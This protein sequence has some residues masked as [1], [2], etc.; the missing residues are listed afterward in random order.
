[1]KKLLISILVFWGVFFSLVSCSPA[2]LGN[3]SQ[4]TF[5]N[6]TDASVELTCSSFVDASHVVVPA[7][8][9]KTV[10]IQ[11][12]LDSVLVTATG[13]YYLYSSNTVNIKSSSSSCTLKPNLA[14]YSL[15][16]LT[17]AT[18]D[19]PNI[20]KHYF[21]CYEDGEMNNRA[22]ATI[23]NGETMYLTVFEN[24]PVSGNVNFMLYSN[25]FYTQAYYSS[26]AMGT[27]K[28]ITLTGSTLVK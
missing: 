6:N 27:T 17:G 5:Y 23:Y 13:K 12:S 14:Y 26:P 16:N 8:G 9:N 11:S 19:F 22:Y 21:F 25:E 7:F 28:A 18:I 1:M 24:K 20:D 15:T 3:T 4:V 10:K 2:L